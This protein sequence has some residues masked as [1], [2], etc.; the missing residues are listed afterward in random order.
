MFPVSATDQFQEQDHWLRRWAG[1]NDDTMTPWKLRP[2]HLENCIVKTKLTTLFLQLMAVSLETTRYSS[3]PTSSTLLKIISRVIKIKQTVSLDNCFG[4][5]CEHLVEGR[6]RYVRVCQWT[7]HRVLAMCW[8][9]QQNFA[10]IFSKFL[11]E[12]FVC[13]FV[14]MRIFAYPK[15]ITSLAFIPL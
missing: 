5:N 6:R 12:S 11:I 10:V 1:S 7:V 15:C 9:W 13:H 4:G 8:R 2:G 3:L 14:D